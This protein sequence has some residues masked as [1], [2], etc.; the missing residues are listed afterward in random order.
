M[1]KI[2]I[3]SNHFLTLYLF[4][5]ELINELLNR[6]FDI[7]IAV[8]S[9]DNSFFEKMGCHIIKVPVDRHGIN[10]IKDATVIFRYGKIIKKQKPDVVLTYTIKPNIYGSIAASFQNV[11][12]I[13]NIT[14]LGTA[15]ENK[16]VLQIITKNL[17]KCAFRK[18]NCVFFQNQ[19]NKRFFENNNIAFFRRRLLPGSGVNL[20]QFRVLDY[21]PDDT[22]EF[23]FISRIMKEKGIDQ[24]LVAAEHIKSK[25]PNTRFHICGFCEEAYE[26]VLMQKQDEGIII[27]HGMV[28]DVK[29]K[30]AITHCT[31][32]PSYHEGMS[33][34]LL[35]SSACGRPCLCSDIP[36][37]REIVDDGE[38]GYLFKPKDKNSLI[39]AIE[40]FI[41]LSHD[42]KMQMGLNARKKVERYF[43]RRIV[44]NA[45]LEEIN[46]ILE[47]K[48]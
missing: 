34:V 18:V 19:E 41:L 22:V 46:R 20:E 42:E 38:G 28:S 10:P 23:L 3:L 30:I 27:Y 39:E 47:A 11:P 6:G 1:K 36:G 25:Y 40:K 16:G 17:Y 32:H 14:G 4:R 29:E 15:V 35:E 8:P 26:D 43:D 44:I 45:Y 48:L 31:V 7:Y 5:R 12:Y 33:N 24:Y 13:A 21:P 2:L 37:C 9:D